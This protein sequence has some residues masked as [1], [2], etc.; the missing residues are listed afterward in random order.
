VLGIAPGGVPVAFEIARALHVPLDVLPARELRIP[1]DQ[2]LSLGAIAGNGTLQLDSALLKTLAVSQPVI[3]RFIV[4]EQQKL[5]CCEQLY[6]MH[7][8]ARETRGR[9]ILLVDDGMA[10]GATM[11]VAIARLRQDHPARIIVAVP[12]AS[13]S[14]CKKLA[15]Q[16]DALVCLYIPERFFGIGRWYHNFP[17][18][19]NEEVCSLLGQT[20]PVANCC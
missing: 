5:A 2:E 10:T 1:G 17:S 11:E 12:V 16:V 3:E 14:A 19:T 8:L 6:H 9:T 20:E 13:V 4:R 15:M 18:V 7:H